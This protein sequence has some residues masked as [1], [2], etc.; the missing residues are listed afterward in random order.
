MRSLRWLLLLGLVE[1]ATIRANERPSALTL[2]QKPNPG[3]STLD[4]TFVN[5]KILEQLAF[6]SHTMCIQKCMINCQPILAENQVNLCDFTVFN[7]DSRTHSTSVHDSNR[8][9]NH[10]VNALFPAHLGHGFCF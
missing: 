8:R 2:G 10:S 3:L 9:K 4:F 6:F 1:C 5:F 7:F